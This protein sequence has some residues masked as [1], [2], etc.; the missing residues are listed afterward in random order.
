METKQITDDDDDDNDDGDDEVSDDDWMESTL[1]RIRLHCIYK[2]AVFQQQAALP[3]A[4]KKRYVVLNYFEGEYSD[5]D[6]A[7]DSD[8]DENGGG[9]DNYKNDDHNSSNIAKSLQS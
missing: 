4:Y 3:N 2:S 9:H 7:D 1:Q 5:D 8:D 6:E